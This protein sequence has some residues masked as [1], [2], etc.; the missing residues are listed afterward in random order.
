MTNYM[1]LYE[2]R[3]QAAA[4]LL[5][6]YSPPDLSVD[7]SLQVEDNEEDSPADVRPNS[8]ARQ[9]ISV[10][11]E[12]RS[13][14]NDHMPAYSDTKQR[15]KIRSCSQKSYWYCTKCEVYLCLQKSRNC[16]RDYH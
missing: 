12:V 14:G 15:C 3:R 13:S 6:A 4:A 8:R 1:T 11:V 7:V 10:P 9:P 2:F 16:F 5:H